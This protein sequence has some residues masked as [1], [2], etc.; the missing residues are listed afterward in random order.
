MTDRHIRYQGLI[1]R[2][3]KFLLIQHSSNFGKWSHWVIPGGGLEP[4]ETPEECII[5]E[6]KEE[7]NLD[8]A[9]ERLLLDEPDHPDSA[10]QRRKTYLCRVL[11]GEAAPGYEPE[12]EAYSVYAITAVSWLDLW[13]ESDWDEE[14]LEDEITYPQLNQFR[15]LLGYNPE[16]GS[17]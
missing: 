1:V 2:D 11:R 13:D 12:L 6:M 5:R 8:V 4:G 10:Y 17:D 3:H 15:Q 14:I 16:N 7:T 9:V